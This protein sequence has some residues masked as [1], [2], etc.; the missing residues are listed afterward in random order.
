MKPDRDRNARTTE[1]ARRVLV[2]VLIAAVTPA[3]AYHLAHVDGWEKEVARAS[4]A[5]RWAD[6]VW[7]LV[8]HVAGDDWPREILA[9]E[10]AAPIFAR[11]LAAWSEIPTADIRWRMEGWKSGIR[12]PGGHDGYNTFVFDP[13]E[14]HGG[15]RVWERRR[16]NRWVAVESDILVTRGDLEFVRRIHEGEGLDAWLQ[17]MAVHGLGH[18]LHLQHASVFPLLRNRDAPTNPPSVWP[19]DSVMSYGRY[20]GIRTDDA[21]GASL[22]RPRRGW[23]RQTGTIS[24]SVRT[25]GGPV[26]YA[27][28]WA[29][30]V[31]PDG[32]AAPSG[33]VGAFSDGDGEFAIEGLAPGSYIL[34]AHPIVKWLASPWF[35][36]EGGPTDVFDLVVPL[37]VRVSAGRET[38]GIEIVM[39]RGRTTVGPRTGE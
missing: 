37:P 12:G 28:L 4:E 33:A 17:S 10:D 11:A 22:L 20:D 23:L 38:G 39:R 32:D 26:R 7:P 16:G 34:Y 25:A 6:D 18:S 14:D 29:I 1:L 31:G 13:L 2:P 5:R 35:V 36:T 24:G 9:P 19:P 30:P 8:W 27:S 15:T 3:A 21:V